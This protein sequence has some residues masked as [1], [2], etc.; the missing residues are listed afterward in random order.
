MP[1]RKVGMKMRRNQQSRGASCLIQSD[2]CSCITFSKLKAVTV[3]GV[4][5]HGDETKL[6][7]FNLKDF[8][9]D[10][11]ILLACEQGEGKERG[12]GKG[13]L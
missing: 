1:L 10:L 5:K 9:Q 3:R 4:N 6:E 13:S 8:E 2:N 12:R 11:G 7:S